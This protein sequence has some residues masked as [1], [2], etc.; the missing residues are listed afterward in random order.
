MERK[1]ETAPGK[2]KTIEEQPEQSSVSFPFELL[3][4]FNI[5]ISFEEQSEE[6]EN[7]E[8]WG[9]KEESKSTGSNSKNCREEKDV[10]AMTHPSLPCSSFL[11]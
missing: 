5:T 9:E 7:Q 11:L 1:D 6:R 10:N 2:N 3:S 4:R 8:R